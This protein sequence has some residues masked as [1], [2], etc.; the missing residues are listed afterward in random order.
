MQRGLCCPGCTLLPQAALK[1]EGSCAQV[2]IMRAEA[3]RE[4]AHVVVEGTREM[5]ASLG[6]CMES[7]SPK[8]RGQGT[9]IRIAHSCK[10]TKTSGQA[11]REYKA[12]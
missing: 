12:S 5:G 9:T 2:S 8:Q 6:A 3:K 4:G 1:E 10:A 7:K 11:I